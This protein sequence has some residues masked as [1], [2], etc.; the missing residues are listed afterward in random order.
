MK[1][2]PDAAERRSISR[3]YA[4][5]HGLPGAVGVV[6]GTPVVFYQRP[7]VDGEVFGQENNS[8]P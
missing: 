5:T 2:W 6:D 3:R 4:S 7:A 1:F 8:M